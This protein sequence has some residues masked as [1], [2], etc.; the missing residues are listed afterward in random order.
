[1]GGS[2]PLARGTAAIR[3]SRLDQVRFIP[4]G[5]G[6]STPAAVPSFVVTV[7]P[8]WRGEQVWCAYHSRVRRGSSPLARGTVGQAVHPVY[9]HRFIPAGAG[10]SPAQCAHASEWSVHPRWRGEQAHV[11]RA[12]LIRLRFIPA[13]AGNRSQLQAAPSVCPVHPRWRG[14]Q[15]PVADIVPASGGSSPLAR[16]TAKKPVSDCEDDRFIPAGAGNSETIAAHIAALFGSSPL[17]RGTE[18]DTLG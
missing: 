15:G 5:A 6:N 4:A 11:D 17:A 3:I 7:H 12:A 10:N 1:M 8:R 2:S 13:G 14:E 18:R 9:Q 16:G